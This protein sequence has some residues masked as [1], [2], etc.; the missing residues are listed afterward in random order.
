[1]C[2]ATC[3]Y[4][5]YI[6]ICMHEVPHIEP[7]WGKPEGLQMNS[8]WSAVGSIFFK[9]YYYY[10]VYKQVQTHLFPLL[11]ILCKVCVTLGAV[12]LLVVHVVF[13]KSVG[14]FRFQMWDVLGWWVAGGILL[15]REESKSCQG[16]RVGWWWASFD[17]GAGLIAIIIWP[18]TEQ[19]WMEQ[20]ERKRE[21]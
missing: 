5:Q 8:G 16:E 15:C 20:R 12:L 10:L 18:I 3:I 19:S 4:I 17:R 6:H 14:C 7:C 21:Y 2:L 13:L 11:N 1:M 9:N